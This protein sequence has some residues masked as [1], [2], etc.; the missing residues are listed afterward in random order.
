MLRVSI[1]KRQLSGILVIAFLLLP[2]TLIAQDETPASTAPAADT[3]ATED[4]TT[5]QTTDDAGSK[6]VVASDEA[7]QSVE[8]AAADKHWILTPYQMRIWLAVDASPQLQALDASVVSRRVNALVD[9]WVGAGWDLQIE[10]PPRK[11]Y[12]DLLYNF[13]DLGILDIAAL[14]E[15]LPEK[16]EAKIR[17]VQYLS[18]IHI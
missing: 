18:L 13:D 14:Y 17:A 7:D 10:V 9:N 6:S 4:E 2:L 5:A 12:T 11:V 8:D 3:A 16:K 1:M 15:P